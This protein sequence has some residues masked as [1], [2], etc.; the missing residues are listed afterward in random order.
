[1][2][3][4]KDHYHTTQNKEK[5]KDGGLHSLGAEVLSFLSLSRETQTRNRQWLDS[6]DDS[7][8]SDNV[9]LPTFFAPI[10]SQI[11]CVFLQTHENCI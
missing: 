10:S 2:N 1:M 11:G 4:R 6:S 5:G 7:A 3:L 9:D 8:E